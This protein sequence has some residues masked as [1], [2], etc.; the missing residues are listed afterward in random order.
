MSFEFDEKV[1]EPKDWT[2]LVWMGV[3]ALFAVMIVA[4]FFLSENKPP[5][6]LVTARHILIACDQSDIADK[7]RALELIKDLR[8]RIENGESFAKLAEEYS[9]DPG[10]KNAPRG[11]VAPLAPGHVCG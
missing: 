9:D 3:A 8:A 4:M 5:Q 2:K 10:T 7:T 11:N 6:S 1:E